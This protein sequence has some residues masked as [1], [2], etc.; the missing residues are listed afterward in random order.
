ML[1]K[2]FSKTRAVRRPIRPN[3][4]IAILDIFFIVT[5]VNQ[6]FKFLATVLWRVKYFGWSRGVGKLILANH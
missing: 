4:L 6:D 5:E 1:G 2:R 3:P